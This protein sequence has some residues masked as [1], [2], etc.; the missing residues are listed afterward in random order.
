[1]PLKAGN[2]DFPQIMEP[3]LLTRSS[4]SI[5]IA[6][7]LAQAQK[8]TIRSYGVFLIATF[9]NVSGDGEVVEQVI[10]QQSAESEE[11][12]HN[13]LDFVI[14]QLQENH[15]RQVVSQAEG[16]FPAAARVPEPGTPRRGACNLNSI[17]M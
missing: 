15:N 13:A 6:Q 11:I 4:C 3:A 1:M 5:H 10:S 12:R 2:G 16:G 8:K 14:R 7:S 17:S 9:K